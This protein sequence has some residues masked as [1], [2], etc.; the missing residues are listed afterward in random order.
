M[1]ETLFWPREGGAWLGE[2]RFGPAPEV[3]TGRE[4]RG[5]GWQRGPRPGLR[6]R[7]ARISLPLRLALSAN[8]FSAQ[9]GLRPGVTHPQLSALFWLTLQTSFQRNFCWTTAPT[10]SILLKLRFREVSADRWL[11][12]ATLASP[13]SPLTSNCRRSC[14]WWAGSTGEQAPF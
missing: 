11:K 8:T 7:E 6:A 12:L 2:L 1:K 5:T 4:E 10:W 9:L 3:C 13:G 14:R